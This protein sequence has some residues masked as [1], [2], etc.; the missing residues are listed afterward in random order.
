MLIPKTSLSNSKGN[1]VKDINNKR[2]DRR[3]LGLACTNA[4]GVLCLTQAGSKRL[5]S[6]NG[7]V[8]TRIPPVFQEISR[9]NIRV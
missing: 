3:G 8:F 1:E 5:R 6:T 9:R 7:A 2:R 4:S